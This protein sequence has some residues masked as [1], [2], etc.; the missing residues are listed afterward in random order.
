MICHIFFRLPADL[1]SGS[2]DVSFRNMD[3][4]HRYMQAE[5]YDPN[6]FVYTDADKQCVYI[7][8]DGM[9]SDY[10]MWGYDR[11]FADKHPASGYETTKKR[12]NA[13]ICG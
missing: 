2:D 9:V 7:K 13:I 10:L 4:V 12:D 11:S 3:A 6:D 5:E 8:K 1:S